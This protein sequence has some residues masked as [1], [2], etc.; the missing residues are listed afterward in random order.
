MSSKSKCIFKDFKIEKQLVTE[1]V[2]SAA[3]R[4]KSQICETDAR[5][6]GKRFIQVPQ[7]PE[8][9]SQR[10]SPLPAQAHSSYR[11]SKGRPF[12]LPNYLVSFGLLGPCPFISLAFGHWV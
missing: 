11:D 12:F 9:W 2:G 10:P 6:K 4:S 8:E 7:D 5:P 1:Q 3:C